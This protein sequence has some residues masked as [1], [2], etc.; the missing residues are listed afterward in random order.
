MK[1]I[2]EEKFKKYG[3]IVTI[4]F[5]A[6]RTDGTLEMLKYAE[7]PHK[8]IRLKRLLGNAL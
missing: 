2:L 1:N 6:N 3:T 7:V 4:D 8:V 5:N